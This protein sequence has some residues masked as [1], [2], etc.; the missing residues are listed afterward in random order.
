M[1]ADSA[2]DE[3]LGALGRLLEQAERVSPR[4]W[5]KARSEAMEGRRP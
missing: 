3:G 4:G 5:R 1:T 2:V